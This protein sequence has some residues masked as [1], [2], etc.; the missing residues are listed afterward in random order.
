MTK[1]TAAGKMDRVVFQQALACLKRA[2]ACKLAAI[3]GAALYSQAITA[4][5]ASLRPM[6]CQI[7]LGQTCRSPSTSGKQLTD[8]QLL[9]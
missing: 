4:I 6:H 5:S 1:L 2:P 7:L 9:G 3:F 8:L